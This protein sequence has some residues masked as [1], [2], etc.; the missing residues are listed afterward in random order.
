M[1]GWLRNMWPPFPCSMIEEG[2]A[3]AR[4]DRPP[5]HYKSNGSAYIIAD[6]YFASK[7]GQEMLE[8]IARMDLMN[9]PI[10]LGDYGLSSSADT[11]DNR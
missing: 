8:R 11:S 3:D 7:A 6:E 5:I 2:Q 4:P 10:D 1:F 9:G